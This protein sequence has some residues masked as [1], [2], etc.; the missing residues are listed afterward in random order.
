MSVLKP[1]VD[2]NP[3]VKIAERA[4]LDYEGE[5]ARK[6]VDDQ[7]TRVGKDN[8]LA[9]GSVDGTM[10]V[11]GALPA[12]KTSGAVVKEGQANRVPVTSIDCSKAE[13]DSIKAGALAHC[14]EQPALAEG[15]LVQTLLFDMMKNKSLTPSSAGQNVSGWENA[16]WAPLES[17]KRPDVAGPWFKTKTFGVPEQVK[18]DSPFHWA[19]AGVSGG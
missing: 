17:T 6:A 10:A 12:L 5:K 15:E 8:L 11:G 1:I 13:L 18:V 19:N 3:N 2:Q 4:N 14:S 9:V 16:P 7:I